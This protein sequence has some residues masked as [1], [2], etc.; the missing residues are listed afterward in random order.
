MNNHAIIGSQDQVLRVPR[1]PKAR[2]ASII[3]EQKNVVRLC[4]DSE[5]KKGVADSNTASPEVKGW[6]L[7]LER[8]LQWLENNVEIWPALIAHTNTDGVLKLM[9]D[10]ERFHFKETTRERARVLYEKCQAHAANGRPP[11]PPNHTIYGT[12]GIM[13]G[14]A[15]THGKDYILDSRYPK[16]DANIYGHNGLQ[17]GDWFALR[18]VALF[19]GAHGSKEGGIAGT[20]AETGAY[21]VVT[22][23][24]AY[25]DLDQD[26][27]DT[28]F[29]SGD[30]SHDNTDP[31]EPSPSSNATLAL[32]A[33]QRS[34]NPVRVLRAAGLGSSRAATLR[35]TVG[36]RYDGLYRVVGMELKTNANGG[37]YEQFK[38]E[39]LEGQLPLSSFVKSRPTAREVRDFDRRGDG[40]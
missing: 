2:V 1:G 25:E 5:K 21:S 22:A 10:N 35:P 32:K 11:P 37:L 12:K 20:N 30:R 19:H 17:V 6:L 15:L 38:L 27:G 31:K 18:L 14:V 23:G 8:F 16:R 4:V 40:Y 29:Y 13:H 28:L 34:G 3:E 9:F 7:R 33:S 39:R 26:N 24:G 36:I